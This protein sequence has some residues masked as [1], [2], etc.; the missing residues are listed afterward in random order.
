MLMIPAFTHPPETNRIYNCR[1]EDLLS[2]VPDKSVD[3][4]L[5]SPPYDNLRRYSG[6]WS[7]DFEYIARQSYRV[8]KQ[9]GVM[10]WVVGDATIDG[11][12]TLTSFEQALYFKKSVGF[13]AWDTMIWQ[14]LTPG[15]FYKRYTPDFE[16][17]FVL[18]KGEPDTWNPQLRRN[19]FGGETAGGGA[20]DRNGF[21]PNKQVVIN[22][23][24]VYENVWKI[25]GGA[26]LDDRN[27]HPAP[28]PEA[29]AE[30]HIL[31]WSNPGDVVLDFF[32]GSGTTAK[33][34]RK[35][36][37]RWMYCDIS[38]QYTALAEKRLSMPYTPDMFAG[39]PAAG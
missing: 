2:A 31:T 6:N 39:L 1:A 14:K 9:G 30:R 3:M 16:F 37:R 10:V 38:P 24:G 29:L 27:G 28:F 34:A 17:M 8:L 4:I 26:S 18:T 35:H 12:E 25:Q 19:K 33:M 23:W 21:K 13:R 11:S 22:E 5:T 36:G 20:R 32:G 15:K 7:F